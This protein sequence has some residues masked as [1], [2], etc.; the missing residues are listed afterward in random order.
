MRKLSIVSPNYTGLILVI[1]GDNTLWDTN[2][3]FE[4]AQRWLLESLHRARPEYPTKLSFE[5]LRRIDDLLILRTGRHEYD[6]QLLVL[7]LISIQ[8]GVAEA[9]AVSVAIRELGEHPDSRDAKLAVEISQTFRLRLREIPPL[10]PSV[11]RSLDEL[12]QLRTRY[13]DR[14][15]LILLSEGNQT[16]I[17]SILKHHFGKK[18]IFDAFHIVK[19]KSEDTLLNARGQGLQV[20]ESVSG[21]SNIHTQLVVV[22][23]SIVSDIVPGNLV[24]ALTI[25][26]AGGYRGAETPSNDRERPRI[27]LTSLRQLPK[28]VGSMLENKSVME[29]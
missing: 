6:F 3:V 29:T 28:L 16:R 15:T 10:L 19:H 9:E 22:G 23:D 2:S 1:D 11:S 26:I 24:G 25:Y 14:L 20:L 12:S 18:T 5:L 27:V 7:A 4:A 21:C 17:R 13:R 8:K